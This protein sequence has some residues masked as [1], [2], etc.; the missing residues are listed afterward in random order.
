VDAD[1]EEAIELKRG[2]VAGQERAVW[3]PALLLPADA[4][5]ARIKAAV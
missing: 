4:E 5:I 3:N 1:E 2:I